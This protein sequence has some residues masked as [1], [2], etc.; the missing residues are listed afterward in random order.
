MSC[1]CDSIILVLIYLFSVAVARQLRLI[2]LLAKDPIQTRSP[3]QE[4]NAS[5]ISMTP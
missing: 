4:A 5:K 1:H 2:F 3:T